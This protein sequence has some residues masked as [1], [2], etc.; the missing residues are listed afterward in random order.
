MRPS[1]CFSCQVTGLLSIPSE[2]ELRLGAEA[3]SEAPVDE[4]LPALS[5]IPNKEVGSDHV[6]LLAELELLQLP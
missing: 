2:R 4:P 5:G 3:A 1:L 6:A